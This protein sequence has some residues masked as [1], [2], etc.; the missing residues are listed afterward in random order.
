MR[1][2][3]Q[4]HPSSFCDAPPP[5][6][7]VRALTFGTSS[8][9]VYR[10]AWTVARISS[11][12]QIICC[13]RIRDFVAPPPPRDV[14]V[15]KSS[16]SKPLPPASKTSHQQPHPRGHPYT[17]L[18]FKP[19]AAIH[20][21]GVRL[22]T[23]PVFHQDDTA[24]PFDDPSVSCH[25]KSSSPPETSTL[26]PSPVTRPP[27]T[28]PLLSPLL[29]VKLR[30]PNQREN[31]AGSPPTHRES[32]ISSPPIP[33]SSLPVLK[34][35]Y[36]RRLTLCTPSV[37]PTWIAFLLFASFNQARLPKKEER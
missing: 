31:P 2:S 30:V 1:D 14:G 37:F 22:S 32:A 26:S 11:S 28:P 7:L 17:F 18:F 5:P 13:T 24:S 3:F 34:E 8:I 6:T 25:Q 35:S 23:N 27:L 20:L 4:P 19:S 29:L 33:A 16:S 12:L 21:P 36:L 10:G 9:D 15:G